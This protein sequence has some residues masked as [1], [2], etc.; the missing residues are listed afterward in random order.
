MSSA[1]LIDR[2]RAI[3]SLLCLPAGLAVALQRSGAPAA[4]TEFTLEVLVFRQPGSSVPVPTGLATTL[5]PLLGPL[6]PG[7]KRAG[8]AL[9]AGGVRT[10]NLGASGAGTVAL[11]ELAAGAADNVLAGVVTLSRGQQL[12]LHVTA[13]DPDC[14]ATSAID[15]R[16]RIK[17]GDRHYFDGPCVGVIVAVSAPNPVGAAESAPSPAAPP[18]PASP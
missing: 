13:T 2:R 15:E 7:L 6:A 1:P 5:G 9:L 12:S 18:R 11:H 8:Y 4:S 14:A 3:A 17:S 16:R 10:F